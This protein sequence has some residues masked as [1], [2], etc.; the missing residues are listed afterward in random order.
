MEMD[1]LFT[2]IKTWKK[3]STTVNKH[4]FV[5]LGLTS[6][7]ESMERD[8]IFVDPDINARAAAKASSAPRSAI[9]SFADDRK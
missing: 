6:F 3:I 5:A 1:F 7:E 8:V 4:L 2:C 9:S